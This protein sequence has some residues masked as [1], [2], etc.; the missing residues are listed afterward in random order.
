VKELW[1]SVNIWESCGKSLVSCFLTHSVVF[2]MRVRQTH[3]IHVDIIHWTIISNSS[4]PEGASIKH[5]DCDVVSYWLV[6]CIWYSDNRPPRTDQIPP[7]WTKRYEWVGKVRCANLLSYLITQKC[8]YFR[9]FYLG[10]CFLNIIT[11]QHCFLC[12][13]LSVNRTTQEVE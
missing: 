4:M 6:W 5:C 2:S 10:F 1:K 9:H 7:L 3:V 13:F 11:A 8:Y 12:R